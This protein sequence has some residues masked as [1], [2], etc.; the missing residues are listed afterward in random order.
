MKSPFEALPIELIEYVVTFLELHDIASLRLTSRTLE[1]K[2]SH[3]SFISF[4]KYKNIELTTRALKELAQITS[5]GLPGCLLQHCTITGLVGNDTRAE[6]EDTE[7]LDLLIQAFQNLKQH[8]PKGGLASLCLRVAARVKAANGELIEPDNFYSWRAVWD[9]ALR[10][11]SIT[12]VAL[13]QSQL[14]VNEHLDV[15]GSLRGCS[16]ACDTFREFTHNFASMHIFASLK[17]LTLNLSMPHKEVRRHFSELTEDEFDALGDEFFEAAAVDRD[18]P[19]R[20]KYSYL[21]LQDI[22]QVSRIMPKLKCL[23]LH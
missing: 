20:W 23:N 5:Q 17:R 8:S 22:M 1:N 21:I 6:D 10:T 11:F 2:A 15:F 19:S 13:N 18:D 12:I 7:S 3:G 14:P 9:G 16:L 4:F